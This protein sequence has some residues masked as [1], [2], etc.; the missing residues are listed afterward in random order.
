MSKVVHTCMCVCV[1]YDLGEVGGLYVCVCVSI[2]LSVCVCVSVCVCTLIW[3]KIQFPIPSHY[4]SLTLIPHLSISVSF[5]HTHI[6]SHTHTHTHTHT[7]REERERERPN[8][9]FHNVFSCHLSSC[10]VLS[11]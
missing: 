10:Q 1:W 9:I 8:L 6:H 2:S 7:G 5:T 4:P 11:I 3:R